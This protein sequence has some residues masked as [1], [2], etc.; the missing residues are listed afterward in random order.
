MVGI[1]AHDCDSRAASLG[2]DER[3][4]CAPKRGRAVQAGQRVVIGQEPTPLALLQLRDVGVEDDAPPS[5]VRASFTRTQRLSLSCHRNVPWLPMLLH[6]HPEDGGGSI[7]CIG[8]L[9][10]QSTSARTTSS[11]PGARDGNILERRVEVQE[12]T[13]AQDQAVIRAI[14]QKALR[15]TFDHRLAGAGFVQDD[16]G[17]QHRTTR[18]GARA[19]RS[20]ECILR[21]SRVT[22]E[23]ST[24]QV[25]RAFE[26]ASSR[27]RNL[28]L[29][30]SLW[31]PNSASI[32]QD[33]AGETPKI[34]RAPSLI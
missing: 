14:Q 4:F 21:P 9:A 34:S 31:R 33:S 13:V 22:M 10:P 11:N 23:A 17:P 8:S 27:S 15:E 12:V 30:S 1:E 28:A 24:S 29:Y 16:P 18:A 3:L 5:L 20:R 19:G 25:V 6:P 26:A 7:F 2:A 32:R